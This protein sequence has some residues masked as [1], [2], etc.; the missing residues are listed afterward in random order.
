MLEEPERFYSYAVTYKDP[1][2]NEKPEHSR[3]FTCAETFYDACYKVLDYYNPEFV[4]ELK[5]DFVYESD[6]IDADY[7]NEALEKMKKE[8]EHTG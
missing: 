4:L 6:V 8:T 2:T 1:M 3:G 7:I 5:M